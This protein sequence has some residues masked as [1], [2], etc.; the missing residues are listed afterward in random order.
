VRATAAGVTVGVDRGTE[1][2]G[3]CEIG[4]ARAGIV[5]L[6][7]RGL[8]MYGFDFDTSRYESFAAHIATAGAL[9]Q[10]PVAGAEDSLAAVLARLGGEI[11]AAM[12]PSAADSERERVFGEAVRSLAVPLRE[13]PETALRTNRSE[14]TQTNPKASPCMPPMALS[15]GLGG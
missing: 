7:V 13:A 5:S 1:V 4:A 6:I 12:A 8:E 9:G 10:L 15:A 2:P 14:P 11:A 3:V